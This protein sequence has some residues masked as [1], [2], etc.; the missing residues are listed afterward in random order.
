MHIGVQ[1]IAGRRPAGGAT[2]RKSGQLV[3]RDG[4]RTVDGLPNIHRQGM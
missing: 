2:S 3:R 4:C 1:Q